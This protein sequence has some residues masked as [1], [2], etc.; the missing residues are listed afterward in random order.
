MYLYIISFIIYFFSFFFN[1]LYFDIFKKLKKHIFPKLFSIY[2]IKQKIYYLSFFSILCILI[3]CKIY[4]FIYVYILFIYK[5]LLK[6]YIY[7][8]LR[9]KKENKNFL[10]LIFIVL[11]FN[12]LIH[13]KVLSR[14]FKNG[15]DLDLDFY[16]LKWHCLYYYFYIIYI[17][18]DLSKIIIWLIFEYQWYI[19][20]LN[21]RYYLKNKKLEFIYYFK[22]FFKCYLFIYY[23]A[24][25]LN[26]IKNFKKAFNWKPKEKK[27]VNIISNIK[28]HYHRSRRILKEKYY[29]KVTKPL[30][31][32]GYFLS[33]FI[34]Y[35]FF[36]FLKMGAN[37][38]IYYFYKLIKYSYS[39][40]VYFC[41]YLWKS[42]IIYRFLKLIGR[43]K[44]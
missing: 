28:F 37:T 32:F 44:W 41:V 17:L 43:K 12:L 38:I 8:K 11:W 31:H 1:K 3:F 26:Y 20:Y 25:I 39:I 6:I 15:I 4:F 22:L 24:D 10:Y 19:L 16:I 5:I 7:V 35:F 14:K 18:K 29:N 21:I 33:N 27:K 23:F 30:L 9:S 40:C 13:L 34:E 2:T 36:V 42:D